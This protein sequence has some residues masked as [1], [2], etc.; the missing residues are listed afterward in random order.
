M[1]V[2]ESSSDQLLVR[3]TVQTRR[4]LRSVVVAIN[5][6]PSREGSV[7]RLRLCE[8]G[9]DG[10]GAEMLAAIFRTLQNGFWNTCRAM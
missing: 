3:A 7:V 6:R 1:S 4:G 2:I 5:P 10:V 8:N 9:S